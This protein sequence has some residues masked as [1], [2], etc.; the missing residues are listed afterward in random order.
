MHKVYI[1]ILILNKIFFWLICKKEIWWTET[2]KI[3]VPDRYEE[4]SNELVT[5]IQDSV[6]EAMTIIFVIHLSL[7]QITTTG[8]IMQFFFSLIPQILVISLKV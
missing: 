8:L 4:N 6:K 5:K 1:Y 2:V 7:H 3:S